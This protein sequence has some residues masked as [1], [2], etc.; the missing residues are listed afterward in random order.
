MISPLPPPE[1]SFS[2]RTAY[3]YIYISIFSANMHIKYLI[4]NNILLLFLFKYPSLRYFYIRHNVALGF[5]GL[6]K[7]CAALFYEKNLMRAHPLVNIPPGLGR[8]RLYQV[9]IVQRCFYLLMLCCTNDPPDPQFS[10]FHKS[11]PK[12]RPSINPSFVG[13]PIGKE[14]DWETSIGDK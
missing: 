12:N 3:A 8:F 2:C 9:P 11:K 1:A 14:A 13:D 6:C 7:S 4:Y 5:R 10:P